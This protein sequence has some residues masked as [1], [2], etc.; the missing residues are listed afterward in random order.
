MRFQ[1]H[2][3]FEFILWF[4]WK[5]LITIMIVRGGLPI[6]AMRR[7]GLLED[8]WG[9]FGFFVLNVALIT[10]L[11]NWSIFPLCKQKL[12]WE[13]MLSHMCF[14][15]LTGRSQSWP[16]KWNVERIHTKLKSELC[17]LDFYMHCYYVGWDLQKL[18][19]K[20]TV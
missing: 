3:S 4:N 6:V 5:Y 16:Q 1:T 18:K 19:K 12:K 8:S 10:E 9:P 2:H 13:R 17:T 15:C 7:W 20:A 14:D 11:S